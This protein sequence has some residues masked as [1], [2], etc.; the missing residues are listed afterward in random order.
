[1]TDDSRLYKRTIVK[2]EVTSSLLGENRPLRI[3]LPPGYNELLSYPVIYCQDGE[4]FFN[5]GRIA[6]TLTR[7][8]LDE[9]LE[10]AIVVGVDV[11]NA[12]RTS[13]YAPEG[14][15]HDAYCQFFAEELL[16]YVESRYPVR[17]ERSERILAGDSLGGTVSLHLA[18][19]YPSLFCRVISLSSAFFDITRERIKQEDDLSWLEIYMLIGT[20]E[21]DV[22]TERG[23]FDFVRENRLTHTFLQDKNATLHYTEK[24]GKHIWG[25]WQLEL[26]AALHYFLG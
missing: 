8:I 12:N 22:T 21:T 15:R 6:T 26:P 3:Y 18:L 25:F 10:P 7:L 23:T 13:E 24:P 17:T 9:D 19:D 2:D 5:F 16:P 4:Q 11:N 20:E 1:M 14:E